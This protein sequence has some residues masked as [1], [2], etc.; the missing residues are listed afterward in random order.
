VN[1]KVTY[2]NL[3]VIKIS[4]IKQLKMIVPSKHILPFSPLSTEV[5]STKTFI[6]AKKTKTKTKKKQSI[7][8]SKEVVSKMTFIVPK[9]KQQISEGE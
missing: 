3:L 4:S 2:Q 9:V 6:K 5:S 1:N 7:E 8:R